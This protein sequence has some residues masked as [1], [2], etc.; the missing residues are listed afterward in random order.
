MAI[1]NEMVSV[2][3]PIYNAEN[4]IEKC[5]ESIIKQSYSELE[6]L[7]VNDGSKDC[8]KEIC[9][10]FAD[11]DKRI[12]VLNKAN[13]GVSSARNTGLEYA[14]GEF[15]CFVDADDWID[16]DHISS[17]VSVSKLADCVIGGYIKEM[18]KYGEICAL[19]PRVYNLRNIRDEEI[20][21]FFINGFVH[22][23]WNK[24]FKTEIIKENSIKFI[25]DIHISE[26]SLFCLEYLIHCETIQFLKKVTYHYFVDETLITLSNKVYS[27]S[28]DIYI[29]VF[30]AIKRLLERGNCPNELKHVILVQ[31]IYPQMYA[32]VLK[33]ISN[34]NMRW[35]DKK[36]LLDIWTKNECCRYVFMEEK[37]YITSKAEKFLLKLILTKRYRVLGVLLKWV[38]RKK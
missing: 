8:S 3:V 28:F 15:C 25:S 24:L 7:L 17:M 1:E 4:T 21:P 11:K 9:D 13:G 37:N 35:K 26:D 29:L 34:K 10:R 31:T 32:S 33:I 20:G 22:P 14:K 36:I 23:C 30:E 38:N 5:I 16:M 18:N 2:I 27:N 19:H 6:I 12:I